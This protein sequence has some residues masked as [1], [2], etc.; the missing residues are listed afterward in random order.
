MKDVYRRN[1]APAWEGTDH[2]SPGQLSCEPP[3]L[4]SP[5]LFSLL[6]FI[7]PYASLVQLYPEGFESALDLGN[8]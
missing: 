5:S 2:D 3:W 7:S 8:E 1:E 4:F 6:F